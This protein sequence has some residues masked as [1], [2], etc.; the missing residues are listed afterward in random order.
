MKSKFLRNIRLVQ[1][2]YLVF[3]VDKTPL[4]LAAQQGHF[5]ISQMLV[6]C[7]ATINATDMVN[8]FFGGC[9]V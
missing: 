9:F 3:Q 8:N 6:K 5:E 7:G 2:A 4:H 1:C